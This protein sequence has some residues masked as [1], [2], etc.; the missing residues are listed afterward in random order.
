MNEAKDSPPATHSGKAG[1]NQ[2]QG[3]V[4]VS[5]QLDSDVVRSGVLPL[6]SNANRGRG[7]RLTPAAQ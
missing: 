4:S 7:R 2:L 5:S 6:P 1:I 3:V